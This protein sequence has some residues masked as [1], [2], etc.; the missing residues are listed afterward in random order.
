[1]QAGEPV[2]VFLELEAR[3]GG[4]ELGDHQDRQGEGR[5]G[6]RQGDPLGGFDAAGA[7]G[8]HQPQEQQ[9]RDPDQG[10]IGDEGEQA[11]HDHAHRAQVSRPATP[12]SIT[13][14]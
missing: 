1:M 4:I 11:G 3:L 12:S 10:G 7:V 13:K 2:E 5:Q 9:G 6:R 8:P 14:A